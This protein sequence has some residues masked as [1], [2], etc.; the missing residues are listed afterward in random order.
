MTMPGQAV[1]LAAGLGM[2]MRPITATMPKPLVPVA[3]KPLIDWGL[4]ALAGVGVNRAAVNVHYL[5]DQLIAHLARRER[6]AIAISDERERLLDSG[7]G[8]V[9]ALALLERA[10]FFV[11]NAD[12]FWI[13]EGE[14]NLSRMASAFDDTLMDG[15]LMLAS[16]DQ[17][18]GHD[19]GTD[20]LLDGEGRLA[21]A[22]KGGRE[23]YVY[24]GAILFHPRLFDGFDAEPHS[25]NRHFDRAIAAGRLFGMP[26]TG[27]WITVGTPD[28]IAPAEAVVREALAGACA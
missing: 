3:G 12:T 16:L 11:L 8:V 2:R 4:D 17:A 21:R 27:R 1:V 23:G 20:F 10:P 26:M 18:T 13:D 15:L 22:P 9:A 24:A 5:P 19:G 7:G 14:A 25:L 28:V 6:P